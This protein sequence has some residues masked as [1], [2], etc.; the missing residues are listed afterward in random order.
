M[1]KLFKEITDG[2]K[3]AAGLDLPYT[4]GR[5]AEVNLRVARLMG[6]TIESETPQ[7]EYARISRDAKVE[8]RTR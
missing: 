2:I 4:S 8:S 3:K 5:S 7:Q 6:Q 1:H